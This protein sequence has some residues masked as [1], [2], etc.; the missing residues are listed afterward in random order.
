MKFSL[1]QQSVDFQFPRQICD[2]LTI[3]FGINYCNESIFA[4]VR[5]RLITSVIKNMVFSIFFNHP[6]PKN[7]VYDMT[8]FSIV[9][10]VFKCG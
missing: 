10:T 4:G 1:Q 9:N 2:P 6:A 8:K 5:G 3:N 7:L